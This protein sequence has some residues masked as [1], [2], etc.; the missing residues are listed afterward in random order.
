MKSMRRVSPLVE[1]PK[2]PARALAGKPEG[3]QHRNT[4]RKAVAKKRPRK[5]HGTE[6]CDCKV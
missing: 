4:T 3:N 1:A 5:V 6:L 2:W